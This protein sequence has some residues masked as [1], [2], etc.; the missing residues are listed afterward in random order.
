[1]SSSGISLGDVLSLKFSDFLNALNIPLEHHA[2]EIL[3]YVKWDGLYPKN[4]VP[5]WHIQRMK[6]GNPISHL[7][8]LKQQK[9]LYITC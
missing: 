7:T 3:D 8:L 6:S 2:L 4:Q 5:M 1:M 9:Q